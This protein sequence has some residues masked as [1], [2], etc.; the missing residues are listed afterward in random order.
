MFN[1]SGFTLS[2][3]LKHET[4]NM[5]PLAETLHEMRAPNSIN[6]QDHGMTSPGTPSPARTVAHANENGSVFCFGISASRA[7]R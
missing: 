3:N 6:T 7:L 4:R 1:V 5:K 2:D